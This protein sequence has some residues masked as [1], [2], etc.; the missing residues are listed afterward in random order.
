MLHFKIKTLPMAISLAIPALC[1]LC[2][3]AVAAEANALTLPS[4]TVQDSRLDNTAPGATKLDKAKLAPRVS[5]TSDSSSLLSDI[6]GVSLN[7]AGG[8]SSL[9]AI[10]GLA[11]DRLRIKVD[12]MDLIASCPNHMNPA[13]SYLDPSNVGV[14]KVYAGVTP[15]SAGGDSIGGTIIAESRA[16][17]FA[18]PGQS[19]TKGEAGAF[20]RGNN[21]ARGVNLSAMHATDA[22]NISYSGATSKAYNY[23]AAADFKSYDFTGRVGDNLPRN[24]VG[25]TAYETRNQ[26]L[27]LAFKN[28]NHLFQ[29][30]VGFQDMPFQLYPN[31]RMDMLDNTQRSVNLRYAGQF[32][33]GT[34]NARAYQEKVDH[35]MDFGADKRYWYGAAS[36]VPGSVST[37]A[38]APISATCAAGMPMVTE[39]KTTGVTV[40]ADMALGQHHVLRVGGEAQQYRVNDW[41][42]ASGGGMYPGAF[43][44]I[45][46]GQRDRSAVFAEWEARK[47]AQ[48]MTLLGARY[49]QVSM[50]AG[51]AVGYNPAGMG[52]QGRDANAFNAQPHQSTDHNLDLT[53]AASYTPN[54]NYAVELGFAHKVRSPNVYERFTWSTWQMAALMNNFVGDGNGY[55]GDLTLKPEWANTLSATFDWHAA[56]GSWGF[57]ATPYYT[58]V[59]DYVDA[60]QWNAATNAV[61]TKP[62]KNQ[63]SVLKYVNQ[64]ARIYGLDL[65]GHMPL[66]KSALGD[67]GLKGI[68]NYTYGRNQDT[69]DGLYNT[70]PHNAK[71]A[72][73]QVLGGWDNS[74]ELLMVQAKDTVSSMRNEVKTPGY[75]LVNL[76]V[77][78]AWKQLRVDLGVENLFDTF[79]RLPTGGAYT[80]QGTTMSN[81]ALPNYPQWGTA[82]PGM[83]RSVYV[84]LNVK[85]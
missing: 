14:L 80:G 51:N 83:G 34:L 15:V 62:A 69:G 35:F 53:A 3:H 81:P 61:A 44:N 31:Q 7:G 78:Y 32:D 50:D 66:A 46:D 43:W 40:K 29:A 6:P 8:L 33:W 73:T 5:A 20:Y 64:S 4:V 19:I 71:L 25:S 63:F 65:S 39:G 1:L 37:Q 52:N 23:T 42:P 22:F 58:E 16:P 48:W 56:D 28:D 17:E 85:F 77:S 11:D 72:I 49:E 57:K 74:L 67:F 18:A 47:S 45:R 21:H 59:A 9:P 68:L 2:T 70:M 13:M 84:G 38:C 36:M 82:V 55:F 27:G 30:K 60:V 54:D 10:H 79:Y 26:S 75:S 76:R 41:W 12:G 24:E